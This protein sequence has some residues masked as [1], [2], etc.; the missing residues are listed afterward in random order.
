MMYVAVLQCVTVNDV[1]YSVTGYDVC[2]SVTVY[3]V[4]IS[5]DDYDNDTTLCTPVYRYV[6]LILQQIHIT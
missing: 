1:C 5:S 4:C 3:D 2:D 6:S